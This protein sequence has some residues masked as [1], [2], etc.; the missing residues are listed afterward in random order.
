MLWT[1]TVYWIKTH[2][3]VT[4]M[5]L[6][7]NAAAYHNILRAENMAEGT[8]LMFISRLQCISVFNVNWCAPR[9]LI[10]QKEEKREREGERTT[11]VIESCV[12]SVCRDIDRFTRGQS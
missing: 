5:S 7:E 9:A 3:L 8:R 6:W 1:L 4:H 11:K 2:R 12:M 10:I